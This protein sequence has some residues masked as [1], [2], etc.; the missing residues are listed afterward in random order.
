[1]FVI[2]GATGKVGRTTIKQLRS[3]GAP[4]RAVVRKSS[5]ADDLSALGC[6]IAAA[7]LN[8]AAAIKIAIRGADAVQVICP[9]Q[10][11]AEDAAGA[12]G[13]TIDAI[14]SALT[15]IRPAK[16]LAISDYG[17]PTIRLDPDFDSSG[18]RPKLCEI[19]FR[20]LCGA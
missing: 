6:E 13:K 17:A 10:A 7:D 18:C 15:E 19:G 9:V 20:S 2:L 12:M 14:A 1:M 11:Q 16:V 5:N 8:E 4:V 3:Q